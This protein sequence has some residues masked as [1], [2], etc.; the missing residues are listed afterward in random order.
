M[1]IAI[2]AGGAGNR[3]FPLSDVGFPKQFLK[4]PGQTSLLQ[5]TVKRF[6][7][8]VPAQDLII[9]VNKDYYWLTLEEL[10]QCEAL[11]AHIICEPVGR[12]TAP[13]VALAMKYCED[14]L[15]AAQ[16]EIILAAPADHVIEPAE[17]FAEV[18]V[19]AFRVAAGGSVAV[20]GVR[21]D[22]AETGYGYIQTGN[23]WDEGY[24]DVVSFTE[25][26]DK[27]TAEAYLQDGSYYWNSGMFAFT[28][29]QMKQELASYRSD[30]LND[31]SKPYEKFLEN[32]AEMPDVSL[33]YA[34]AEKSSNL[35]M[36]PLT[37]NW[38]D[39]GSWDAVTE[40]MG[41]DEEMNIIKGDAHQL[42]CK[43]TM[44]FSSNRTVAGIGLENIGVVETM[45]AVLVFKKGESQKVK[46]MVTLLEEKK[47]C[48]TNEATTMHRPWGSYTI[49]AKGPGYKVKRIIVKPGGKLSM[50]QHSERSEHWTVIAGRGK[51]T[52][53][54]KEIFFGVHEGAHIAVGDK[55]RLENVGDGILEI[56]EVQNGQYLEED[57]IIRFDDEYGRE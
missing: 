11:A 56:I 54:D 44:L 12:N 28:I 10:R 39:V 38:N 57:D 14:K 15:G 29:G 18:V 32:F 52:L 49:I 3:L 37:T 1:K 51:L 40:I 41:Q 31:Y 8:V 16:E 13:A 33:D 42:D 43:N 17:A 2:L 35:K 26:P 30:I 24:A 20:L 4:L 21:A 22:R 7:Q 25:K 50:Q 9:V 6:L 46:K 48:K 45:N 23:Q 27:K 5:Q 36:L 34:F 19:K 47:G 55:H 53:A